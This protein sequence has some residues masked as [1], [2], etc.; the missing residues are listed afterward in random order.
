[1]AGSYPPKNKQ[2]QWNNGSDAEL[3]L[4]WQPFPIETFMPKINDSLLDVDKECPNADKELKKI[5]SSEKVINIL[6]AN[7]LFLDNLTHFVGQEVNTLKL[8]N[9]LY[10]DLLIEYNRG[11]KWSDMK[12]WS[13]DYEKVVFEKLLPLA[14]FLWAVEW[15]NKLIERTR[16]GNLI[17]E[18]VNNMKN[19]IDGKTDEELNLFLYSTHDTMLAVLMDALNVYNNELIPFSASLLFELHENTSNNNYFVRIYYYNETLTD[20]SPHLLSLPNCDYL[21][22]CPL[23]KFF[24]L[25]K[26]LI[27]ED[28]DKECGTNDKKVNFFVANIVILVINLV[29]VFVLVGL[30]VYNILLSKSRHFYSQISER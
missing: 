18:L 2:W 9:R 11:Y 21:T 29:L 30:I 26:E 12:I 22:D 7:K 6:N 14:K 4:L 27:P 1:L 23:D 19:K 10:E 13:E 5:F 28:W 24:S 3:G 17:N 20:K 25:T 8:A 15:D 16:A